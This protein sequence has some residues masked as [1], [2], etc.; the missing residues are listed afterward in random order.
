MV[1]VKLANFFHPQMWSVPVG[2]RRSPLDCFED[3]KALRELIRKALRIWP[4]RYSVNESNLRR[5]L[6]TFSHTAGVSNFRPTA[7]K[8][9][10]ER[11]SK[12]GNTILDFSAGY[13]GRLL[14]CMPL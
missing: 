5:M 12:S 4:D 13:G 3:D 9:I 7:A 2:P 1:G 11:Y 6:K 8:A 10:Y 14:G